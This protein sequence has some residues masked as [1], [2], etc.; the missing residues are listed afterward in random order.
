MAGFISGEKFKVDD[1]VEESCQAL[2]DFCRKLKVLKVDLKEAGRQLGL[3]LLIIG[4]LLYGIEN[5]CSNFPPGCVFKGFVRERK[6]TD[7]M[8]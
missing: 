2:W 4:L 5:S 8:E 6:M 3:C 1:V 7:W